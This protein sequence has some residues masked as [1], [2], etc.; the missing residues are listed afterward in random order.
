LLTPTDPPAPTLLR[1]PDRWRS[2]LSHRS[3][4]AARIQPRTARWPPPGPR[5]GVPDTPAVR[6]AAHFRPGCNR[7]TP[8]WTPSPPTSP[9]GGHPAAAGLATDMADLSTVRSA[10]HPQFQVI[11]QPMGLDPVRTAAAQAADTPSAQR[12]TMPLGSRPRP[13][14]RPA[15]PGPDRTGRQCGCSLRQPAA[16]SI[17]AARRDH[18]RRCWMPECPPAC[19]VR[20][21]RGRVRRPRWTPRSDSLPDTACP[22][23]PAEHCPLQSARHDEPEATRTGN[24]RT[25]RKAFGHPR[26]PRPQGGPP[27]QPS[28]SY[29][30]GVCGLATK[31][32]SAAVPTAATRQLLGVALPSKQRLGALLSSENVGSSVER[33]ARGQVLWRAGLRSV[34]NVSSAAVW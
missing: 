32:G 12:P 18:L 21:P 6:L 33:Q 34:G 28:P 13:P 25:I 10:G 11:A 3:R 2:R 29:G 9:A 16:T 15:R 30:A 14:T 7:R 4:L 8:V 27:G 31:V 1:Q 20:C 5:R 23:D 17:G 24:R 26:S 22:V 19:P